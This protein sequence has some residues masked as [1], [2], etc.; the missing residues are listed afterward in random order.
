[1]SLG[2]VQI[3]VIFTKFSISMPAA[4]SCTCK[5]RHDSA[6]CASAPSGTLPSAGVA[7]PV[8]YPAFGLECSRP[9]QVFRQKKAEGRNPPLPVRF[10]L[11]EIT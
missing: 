7:R 2:F 4:R 5:L 1:M 3:V 11:C 9:C 8:K 10:D 6:H